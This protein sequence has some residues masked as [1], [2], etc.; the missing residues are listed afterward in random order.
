[1]QGR[2]IISCG[3]PIAVANL[4]M[5]PSKRSRRKTP[6][7]KRK[8]VDAKRRLREA[9]KARFGGVKADKKSA[10]LFHVRYYGHWRNAD[11]TYRRRDLHNLTDYLADDIAAALKIDDKLYRKSVIEDE[12]IPDNADEYCRVSLY[13]L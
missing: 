12:D 4:P 1:M 13:R 7:E 6:D 11:G 3:S 5:P 8:F 10:Y 2:V 9:C